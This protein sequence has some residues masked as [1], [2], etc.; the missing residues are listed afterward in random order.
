MLHLVLP[1]KKGV[2]GNVK[3]EGGLGCSD[4]EMVAFKFLRA[5]DF[6]L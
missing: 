3:L 1:S 6:G 2:V 4:Y 5:V